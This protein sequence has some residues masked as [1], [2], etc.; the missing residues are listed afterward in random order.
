MRGQFYSILAI[1]ITIPIVIFISYYV[2]SQ[3]GETGI[4]ETIVAD[5]IH[6]VE[7]SLENDF[8]KAM[9]TSGKRALIAGDD[10]VVMSGKA[11][12]DSIAGIKE[13]MENGTIEGNESLLM[14]NNTLGNWTSKILNVPVNFEVNLSFAG[15]EVSNYDSFNINSSANLN[16]SVADELGI[17]RI[18][19]KDMRYEAL[20]YVEKAEDPIFTLKT[21]GVLTR[22]IKVSGYPYRAKK[23]VKGGTNSSGSCSGNVT[24]NK[25][26]CGSEILVAENTSGVGF[27]CFSGFVIED[28]VNLTGN[29]DCYM[30]GNAS[31]LD[32]ITQAI[33]ETGYEKV[34]L[35]DDTKSV[36]H[37]PV[38]EEID[39]KYYFPGNGPNFL[40]RL[41]GDL[42]SSSDGM[43]T[44]VNLPEL[45]VYSIPIKENVISVAYIYF[46]DQD[47]IGYP[48]RGLQGW[49]RVNKTF[50]DRYGLTE[51]CDGC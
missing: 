7:K 45:Q 47:Y 38:R 17:A 8:G 10:Y 11:M 31:A 22:S 9:V 32:I 28:S 15:L 21:N 13:L 18:D 29:S 14:M 3:G 19:K 35:D 6:Q 50:A 23:L 36:W 34:Y 2:F 43:E 4:Y 44:F 24:F 39:N 26:E 16:V 1:F 40:K 42:N 48:V 41:E 51:L 20:I 5:Q 12:N 46:R 25:S 30:T 27:G 37:L 49:F 33:S